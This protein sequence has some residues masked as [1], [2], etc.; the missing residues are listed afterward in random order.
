MLHMGGSFPSVPTQ[1]NF[2][3]MFAPVNSQWRLFG[4]SVNLGQAAPAAPQPQAAAQPPKAPA[5]PSKSTAAP[6]QPVAAPSPV[7]TPKS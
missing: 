7:A 6:K 3:L 5:A 1:V 4:L 2:E